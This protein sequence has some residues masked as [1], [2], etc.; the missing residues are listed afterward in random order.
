MLAPRKVL[1]ESDR[2]AC[3]SDSLQVLADAG[4]QWEG[5]LSGSQVQ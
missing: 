1:K 5:I 3:Y 4:N 2:V